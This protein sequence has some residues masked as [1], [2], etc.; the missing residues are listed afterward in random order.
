MKGKVLQILGG[1]GFGGAEAF[2]MN[3]FRNM[4][5]EYTFDFAVQ[6]HFD[7][8]VSYEKE[9][10]HLGGR[11]FYTGL[12][13]DSPVSYAKK[14]QRIIEKNG[15]YDAIHIHVNEQCGI[16][17]YGAREA[18]NGTII[19]HAH[20]SQYGQKNAF[21][22]ILMIKVRIKAEIKVQVIKV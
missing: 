18:C 12:F 2:V 6:V 3:Q 14:V 8:S 16:A 9:I 13:R 10:I 19:V 15:P 17:A 20:S 5:D 11:I 7:Q 21:I 1:I 22:K 4:K